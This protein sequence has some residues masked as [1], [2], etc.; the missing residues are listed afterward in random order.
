LKKNK[1]NDEISTIGLHPISDVDI[2][3]LSDLKR[4]GIFGGTFNPIHNAHMLAAECARA[5][6]RL[7]CV[8]FMP[9]GVPPVKKMVETAAHRL[10]MTK[11]ACASNAD[12]HVSDYETSND[13]ISYSYNTCLAFTHQFPD[14]D[15]TFICGADAFM[16][17]AKWRNYEE[18]LSLVNF[19]IVTRP[20]IMEGA[21][22]DFTTRIEKKYGKKISKVRIPALEISSADIRSRIAVGEKV[23]YLMPDE[24]VL[25][26]IN[27]GLYM[28][29]LQE[30]RA[31]A[32]LK[33]DLSQNRY[34]HS[35]AVAEEAVRLARIYG[36]D[37]DLAYEAGLLHDCAKG[38]SP[39]GLPPDEA[40]YNIE[41]TEY[42]KS[43][44][45]T[46]H[47]PLG[48]VRART[49][50]G[51]RDAQ[52]LNAIRYHTIGRENMSMLEKIVFVADYIEPGRYEDES[53][54]SARLAADTDI[55]AA[56]ELKKRRNRFEH[57]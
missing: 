40:G 25:Y 54:R 6:L 28:R 27:N 11:A 49:V 50:Y 35:L 56:A 26:A 17:I 57:S 13:Q 24:A 43:K 42:E 44:P 55:D 38:M 53:I 51:V 23:R 3:R 5:A 30:P 14:A 31:K 15:I 12:F 1:A 37:E 10:A 45:A 20:G 29:K 33:K 39:D 18:L 9:V 34:E 41:F 47:A 16:K 22:D 32:R 36:V 52:V 19:C 8:V 46:I 2:K 48:A 21:L 4:I 7:S